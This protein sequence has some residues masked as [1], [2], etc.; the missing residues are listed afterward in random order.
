MVSEMNS[1]TSCISAHPQDARR[2]TWIIVADGSRAR[3]FKLS[4]TDTLVS[5]ID[6]ESI[7]PTLKNNQIGADRPGRT[8][9][10]A[11]TIRHEK[12]PPT[13]PARQAAIE[14]AG[15]VA[16]LLEA[17]RKAGSFEHLIVVAPPRSIGDLRG[18]M[19]EQLKSV[20]TAEIGK[21]LSKL[22]VSELSV[23]LHNV[24]FS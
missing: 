2:G 6:H 7:A 17:E 5:A 11:G 18:A 4:S 13:R 12:E 3:F 14:L 24:I 16:I 8:F 1:R 10:S 21:D 15:E 20:V 22:S 23:R 19:S 9:E